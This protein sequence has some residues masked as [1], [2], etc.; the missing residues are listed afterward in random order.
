MTAEYLFADNPLCRMLG[1]RYP[2]C[3]AGMFQVAYGDLAAAVS[4]AG[5]LGVIGAAFM[6]PEQLRREIRLVKEETERPFGVDILFA[7]VEGSDITSHDYA[8][9]VRGHIEVVFEEGVRVLVSG[10]GDPGGVVGRAHDAGMKVMSLVGT[11][12]QAKAVER[13]GVD[14]VIA[15][16]HEGGGHVGRIGT[17]S[18]VPRV[19]DSVAVPVLA[20]GGLA[21]GRGL[22]AALAMGA[23]GVWMGTRFIATAEAHAHDNYKHRIA[24]IDEDGTVVTRAH[25]GKP[26]RMI[27]NRFTRSWEG[28]E[29]EIQ[30]YPHQLREV[31]EPLSFLG[32]QQGDVDNGVLPCGQSA[33]LIETVDAAGDVVR[34][35]AEEA[36]DVLAKLPRNSPNLV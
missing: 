30:P 5:G 26:N 28:R 4:N 22:V 21:D 6:D 35:I 18:L 7:R 23:V 20:A 14:V 17:L 2:I 10:L 27:R 29:A 9:E 11:A 1:I 16:G 12:K 13:S 3:Q 25:S 31:G 34:A 36:A 24:A 19:V 15:S 8:A 33:G 32:R